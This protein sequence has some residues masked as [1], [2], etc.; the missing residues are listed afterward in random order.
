MLKLTTQYGFHE[1]FTVV[2]FDG[3]NGNLFLRHTQVMLPNL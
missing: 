2:Y 3:K 1:L